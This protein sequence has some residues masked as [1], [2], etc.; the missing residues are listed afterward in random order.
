MARAYV[1]SILL[2]GALFECCRETPPRPVKTDRIALEE[3]EQLLG[4]RTPPDPAVFTRVLNEILER[5]GEPA[6]DTLID[7]VLIRSPEFATGHLARA[8]AFFRKGRL[9]EAEAEA[10]IALSYSHQQD[11]IRAAEAFLAMLHKL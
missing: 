5:F 7:R 2:A 6:A 1:I 9:P 8:Q 11:E 4:N 3:A 10:N